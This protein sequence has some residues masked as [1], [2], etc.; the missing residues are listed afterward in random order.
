MSKTSHSD[1]VTASDAM[2]K[3]LDRVAKEALRVHFFSWVVYEMMHND[4]IIGFSQ[5]QIMVLADTP[6]EVMELN[7]R[8]QGKIKLML[9]PEGCK[10]VPEGLAC[11]GDLLAH[12]WKVIFMGYRVSPS[13]TP[14]HTVSPHNASSMDFTTI[15]HQLFMVLWDVMWTSL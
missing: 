5:S 13:R 11:M 12:G 8:A 10:G 9:A 1:W 2:S 4:P 3:G 7:I 14:W 6:M 15:L